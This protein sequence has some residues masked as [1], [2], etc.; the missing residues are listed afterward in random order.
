MGSGN[1]GSGN[2]GACSPTRCCI[3]SGPR[4]RI[5]NTWMVSP[6]L[7]VRTGGN[8]RGGPC[9]S[10]VQRIISRTPALRRKR[11]LSRRPTWHSFGC[12]PDRAASGGC[13]A[14]Y[15]EWSNTERGRIAASRSVAGFHRDG[16]ARLV[17]LSAD[18]IWCRADPRIRAGAGCHSA[19]KPA[20]RR[21]AAP[22]DR[23][24]SLERLPF[25]RGVL[26]CFA[27]LSPWLKALSAWGMTILALDSV[28][29]G[30][31]LP[32]SGRE[33]REETWA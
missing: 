7:L 5:W 12:R 15:R 32:E 10:G 31:C 21:L 23:A 22:G 19:K 18:R 13:L 14:P 8:N 1:T 20:K 25:Q 6:L 11:T 9:I 29:P 27:A 33:R 26:R 4:R 3:A 2:A 28:T 16:D 24:E 30:P 17:P